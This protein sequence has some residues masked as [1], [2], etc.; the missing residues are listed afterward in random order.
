MNIKTEIK[1]IIAE[2]DKT[3]PKAM[4]YSFIMSPK[5]KKLF[6]KRIKNSKEYLEFGM[7]GSTFR[8]LQK[9][10]ANVYSIDSSS[11]WISLMREYRQIRKMER[12]KRLSLFHVNIGP[13][14]AWG[15]PIDNSHKEKF[16]NYSSH[17]FN[18]VDK[19]VIDTILIDG[20]FRVACAL[21][22]IL[23]CHKNKKL[24][25]IIHD[26]WNREEYHVLLKYFD[27]IDQAESLGVF[28]IKK[29]IDLNAIVEEYELYKYNVE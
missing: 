8:V 9:S 2:I 19:E 25:I 28:M 26:F 5:E 24:Q 18:L 22:T 1:K 15:R 21:K 13:T 7:G 3:L 6:D 14:R 17:I 12:K 27:I 29:S 4:F 11:D 23:E 10:K 16:P 20:R